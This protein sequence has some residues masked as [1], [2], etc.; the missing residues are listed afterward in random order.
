MSTISSGSIYAAVI[1]SSSTLSLLA[2]STLIAFYMRCPLRTIEIY[3]HFFAVTALHDITIST[4]MILCVPRGYHGVCYY[5][6]VATGLIHQ[7]QAGVALL[8]LFWFALYSSFLILT[9]S[10]VYRY[11]Y[12]CRPELSYLYTSKMWMLLICTVNVL[13]LSK[14]AFMM[15]MTSLPSE[16]FRNQIYSELAGMDARAFAGVSLVVGSFDHVPYQS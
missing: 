6:T 11:I 10:F 8:M 16:E 9:N 2:N 5:I 7:W 14:S 15:L 13:L 4:V 3:K 12:V 1:Y